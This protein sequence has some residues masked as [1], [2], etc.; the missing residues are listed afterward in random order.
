MVAPPR[1]V[2]SILKVKPH[3]SSLNITMLSPPVS[4]RDR[5]LSRSLS[6]QKKAYF[7]LSFPLLLLSL[8]VRSLLFVFTSSTRALHQAAS[9]KREEE[10]ALEPCLPPNLIR[11]VLGVFL[12]YLFPPTLH[13]LSLTTRKRYNRVVRH[14]PRLSSNLK[15][16]RSPQLLDFPFFPS[17]DVGTRSW[18]MASSGFDLGALGRLVT[19]NATRSVTRG[20]HSDFQILGSWSSWFP[21]VPVFRER[22]GW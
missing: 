14:S 20:I 18:W 9:P 5:W 12:S 17:I 4:A 13:F 6:G 10:V 15:Q 1:L 16:A 21:Q 22:D 11:G 3:E 19:R 7:L 2:L 8:I